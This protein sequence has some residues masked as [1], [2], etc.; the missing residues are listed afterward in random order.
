MF[1]NLNSSF[2]HAKTTLTILK[3]ALYRVS[4]ICDDDTKTSGQSVQNCLVKIVI[5]LEKKKWGKL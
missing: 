2:I 1:S 3:V 4:F 5:V